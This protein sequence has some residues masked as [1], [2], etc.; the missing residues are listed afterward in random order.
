MS[1]DRIIKDASNKNCWKTRLIALMSLKDHDCQRSKDVILRL[2]LHD[3]VAKV[4]EAAFKIAQSKNF[5]VKGKPIKLEKTNI[6]Y[7]NKNFIKVFS[8]IRKEQKMNEFELKSFK[9]A[10]HKLNPEMCDVMSAKKENEFDAWIEKCYRSLPK[11][12]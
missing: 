8:R 4:K 2:A 12:K 6:G 7:E 5:T 10:L 1:L 9:L 11:A 3:R